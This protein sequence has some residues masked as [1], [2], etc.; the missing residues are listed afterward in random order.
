MSI[1][2]RDFVKFGALSTFAFALNHTTVSAKQDTNLGPHAS[3][4]RPITREEYLQRQETA[5]RY[6][7]D[8]GID[9]IFLTGGASMQRVNLHG[10]RRLSKKEERSSR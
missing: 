9:A 3:Q 7:R 2:R 10:S 6:M 5:R 4:A 8:A 1:D